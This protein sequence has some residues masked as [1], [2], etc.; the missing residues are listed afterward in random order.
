MT[1]ASLTNARL[2]LGVFALWLLA[3][4][5]LLYIARANI[6]GLQMWDPDDYLRLQQVRDWLGGQ[7]FFDITQYRID[8]PDGVTMHWSRIGDLP[9]AA[10]I[11][12]LR[13]VLGPAVAELV[14]ASAV[15]LLILGGSLSALALITAR[16]AGRR[17]A[18]VAAMLATT[19]PLILFHVMPLRIDHHGM[20]TMFGLFAVAACFDRNALR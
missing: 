18:L 17:A 5:I 8:P 4:A 13:P 2:R 15:P 12:L 3:C 19:A 6:A 14:A 10:L 11:L 20:Q 7:S 16:L 9:I 1:D